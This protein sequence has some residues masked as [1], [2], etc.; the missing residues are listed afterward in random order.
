MTKYGFY[1]KN[2]NVKCSDLNRFGR[3]SIIVGFKSMIFK[4]LL[5]IKRLQISDKYLISNKI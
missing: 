3:I 4:F 2:V 1:N 5:K